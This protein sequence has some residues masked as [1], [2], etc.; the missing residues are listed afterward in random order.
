MNTNFWY[1]SFIP[2]SCM[3]N[4]KGVN[5]KKLNSFKNCREAQNAFMDLFNLALD[6]II[7]EGLPETCNNRF[8]QMQLLIMGGACIYKDPSQGYQSLGALPMRFNIYG[9]PESGTAYGFFGEAKNVKFFLDGSY[10]EDANAV[11]CRDNTAGYPFINYVITYAERLANIMRAMDT[12][13]Q[14]LQLPY[15][16]SCEQSQTATFD[17]LFDKIGEHFPYVA[18]SDALNPNAIN[19]ISLNPNPEILKTLWEQY[20]NLRNQARM[21]LG[22]SS[23]ENVDKKER[24]LVDEVNANE[25]VTNDYLALRLAQ[26]E[27]FCDRCNKYFGLN[28]KAKLNPSR[29]FNLKPQDD[30]KNSMKG[31]QNNAI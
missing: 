26:Q 4:A 6:T 24:L 15:I 16:I 19:A 1:S 2:Y 30:L 8:L 5:K 17:A 23:A 31:E 20:L 7:I 3:A 25:E 9:E 14:N 27:E 12:S 28:M 29:E 11:F 22:I 21:F 18:V 10:N 13:A